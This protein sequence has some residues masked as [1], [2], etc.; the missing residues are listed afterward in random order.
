MQKIGLRG[1]KESE[2]QNGV[3]GEELAKKLHVQRQTIS[4]LMGGVSARRILLIR[5]QWQI[6]LR[7]RWMNW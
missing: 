5:S 6:I 4:R 7:F 2:K 3:N 1:C